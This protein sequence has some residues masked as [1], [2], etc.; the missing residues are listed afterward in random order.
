MPTPRSHDERVAA[1]RHRL[2]QEYQMWLSTGAD[3]GPHLIP[4][5]FVEDG[6]AIVTATGANSKTVRNLRGSGRARIAV[7]TTSDVV[8]LD[9]EWLSRAVD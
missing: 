9:G 4:V 3:D 8:M 1:A 5:A 2:Q 7:G 6:D